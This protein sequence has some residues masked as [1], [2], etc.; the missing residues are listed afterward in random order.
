MYDLPVATFPDNPLRYVHNLS[1]VQLSSTLL[2]VL[3]LGP[4]FCIDKRRN[5]QLEL[6]VQFENLFDQTKDLTPYTNEDLEAFKS[7]LVNCCYQYGRRRSVPNPLVTKKHIDALKE[8]KDNKDIII[9]KPDKGAGIVLL[10]KLDYI[11]K[12]ETILAD[13]H[14][15][16]CLRNEKDKTASIEQQITKCLKSFKDEGILSE[17]VYESIRPTGSVIP[18]LYG[19]PKIHKPGVP[20]RPILSMVN[21]PYHA[22][23]RW[24]AEL[25]EPVRQHVSQHSL[26]DTFQFVDQIKDSNIEDKQMFSLDVQSLFTN[27][28]LMETI[29]YICEVIREN[30]IPLSI[31]LDKLKELLLRCTLNVQFL[32]NGQIYRQ[33]DGVAMG[34]PLGPLMADM[35]MAKLENN[36][37]KSTIESLAFYAR[38][39][40]DIFCLAKANQDPDEILTLFDTAHSSVRFT[41]EKECNNEFAFLDVSL[42][43]RA[44][45]SI[46]RSIYRKQTHSGQ[47]INFNSFV[48]IRLKRNLITNLMSRARYICSEDTL[49]SS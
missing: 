19:L 8:L 49:P 21:S 1:N 43:R 14:K 39:V 23:A 29:D 42:T 47:Y 26:R 5:S 18:R 41:I 46:R 36:Q 25:L 16:S 32:F 4:K 44:D 7:A 48:P 6:E 45:G 17:V 30:N 15:F 22:T 9:T 24:L 40:D 11:E 2:E 28:P 37:L 34:S 33:K 38:Y 12:M 20:L 10:N 35:F 13:E 27:I 3:S 31:P